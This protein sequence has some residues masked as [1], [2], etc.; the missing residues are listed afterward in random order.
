MLIVL[1]FPLGLLLVVGF[2]DLKI[3]FAF[4][5]WLDAVAYFSYWLCAMPILAVYGGI[6]TIRFFPEKWSE[7]LFLFIPVFIG[8]VM[9]ALIDGWDHL[10][11]SLT[12]QA[13]AFYLGFYAIALIGLMPLMINMYSLVV[14]GTSW[15]VKVGQAVARIFVFGLMLAPLMM[16]F[17]YAH[18]IGRG[19]LDTISDSSLWRIIFFYLQIVFISLFYWPRL[20]KLYSEGRL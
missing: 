7:I 9:T 4:N 16:T 13:V 2:S 12:I 14:T 19:A 6:A 5:G 10:L 18:N 17:I 8:V 15:K 3:F 20:V 11:A 1:V